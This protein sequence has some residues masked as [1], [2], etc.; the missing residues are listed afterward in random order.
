METFKKRQKA[1]R[2]REAAKKAARKLE[3]RNEKTSR[4]TTL[5]DNLP[6]AETSEPGVIDCITFV[7]DEL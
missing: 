7:R 2:E 3:R 4:R 1:W 5:E 6:T